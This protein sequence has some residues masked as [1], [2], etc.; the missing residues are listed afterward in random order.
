MQR[1]DVLFRGLGT[2]ALQRS[3]GRTLRAVCSRRVRVGVDK[4]LFK[5]LLSL[6][7][8]LIGLLYAVSSC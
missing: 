2:V 1:K 7:K 5:S 4:V 3:C 6:A 8:I